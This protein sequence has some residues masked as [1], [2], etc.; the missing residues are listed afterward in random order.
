MEV[1]VYLMFERLQ[2][3]EKISAELKRGASLIDTKFRKAFQLKKT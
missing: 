1:Y 3:T 2:L